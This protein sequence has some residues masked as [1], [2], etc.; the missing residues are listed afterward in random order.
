MALISDLGWYDVNKFDL[1]W[2]EY[3]KYTKSQMYVL[4]YDLIYFNKK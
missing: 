2:F 1:I 4:T 3:E